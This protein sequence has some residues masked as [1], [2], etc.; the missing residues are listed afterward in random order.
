M[1]DKSS[2][3]LAVRAKTEISSTPF[4][5]DII[6]LDR[7]KVSGIQISVANNFKSIIDKITESN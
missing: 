5:P 2:C 3:K 4:T 6:L 1:I 7:L